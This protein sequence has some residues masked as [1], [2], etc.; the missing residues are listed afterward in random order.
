MP[1]VDLI[2]ALNAEIDRLVQ[3][4]D[5]LAGPLHVAQRGPGRPK[6]AA[7][8]PLPGN[9]DAAP[10]KRTMSAEGKLRIAA[11]Q[12]KRWAKQRKSDSA[13]SKRAA[14]RKSAQVESS[15]NK[16]S[17]RSS[18]KGRSSSPKAAS[19]TAKGIFRRPRKIAQ[20]KKT[21]R[22]AAQTASDS[23]ASSGQ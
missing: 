16:V 2:T 14:S 8:K 20:S 10:K 13:V 15:A 21:S 6:S 12:K 19:N 5:L 17:V 3:A 1:I 7:T 4:R 9:S 11:A 23:Q 18:R 22:R